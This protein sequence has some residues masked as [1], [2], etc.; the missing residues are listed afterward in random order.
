[1]DLLATSVASL[2]GGTTFGGFGA[3][4]IATGSRGQATTDLVGALTASSLLSP[5]STFSFAVASTFPLVTAAAAFSAAN[6]AAAAFSVATTA[7]VAAAVQH[8]SLIH[9]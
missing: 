5:T 4:I 1:M 6:T 7:T 2:A 3:A 9:I 8:L